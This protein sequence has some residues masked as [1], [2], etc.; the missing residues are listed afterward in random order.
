MYATGLPAEVRLSATTKDGRLPFA[1]E[2]SGSETHFT[3]GLDPEPRARRLFNFPRPETLARILRDLAD[4]AKNPTWRGKVQH[5]LALRIE[6]LR[7]AQ[8][9]AITAIEKSL[10][11]QRFE[12]SLV[13]M[14]TGAGKTYAAVTECYRL[15]RYGGFRRILFLVDRQQPG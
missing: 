6:P 12:R 5:L 2:A 15:L 3:N 1:F 10:A 7:P 13:Q 11:K 14:A 9:T 8:V 4:D